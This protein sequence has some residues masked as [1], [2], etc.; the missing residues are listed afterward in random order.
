MNYL[1]IDYGTKRIGLAIGSDEVATA[2]VYG[3]VA[4]VLEVAEVVRKEAID[5]VVIGRPLTMQ[6]NAHAMV[7]G[8]EIFAQQ[9]QDLVPSATPIIFEDERLSSRYADSLGGGKAAAGRDEIAAVA[10]LQSYLDKKKTK[11]AR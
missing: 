2:V 3:T 4:D 11:P 6:G 1:G 10:I 7:Q 5:T 8:A 9:L